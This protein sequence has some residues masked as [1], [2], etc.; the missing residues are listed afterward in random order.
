MAFVTDNGT[1]L[2]TCGDSAVV[3]ARQRHA[4]RKRVEAAGARVR[5][6]HRQ[7]EAALIA[8]QRRRAAKLAYR[9]RTSFDH[10]LTELDRAH[11]EMGRRKSLV[12]LKTIASSVSLSQET[13]EPYKVKLVP[14]A[15]KPWQ[16]RIIC[17]FG[18]VEKAR[19]RMLANTLRPVNKAFCAS[20]QFG[21]VNG[22]R[23]AAIKR[24]ESVMNDP[25]KKWVATAD[26]ANCYSSIDRDMLANLIRRIVPGKVL[27]SAGC[28][29]REDRTLIRTW[30][31]ACHGDLTMPITDMG[32]YAYSRR[33]I[34][35]G[36]AASSFIAD[37][38]IGYAL[39]TI[40]LPSGV[41]I[42]FYADDVCILGD[43]KDE[44]AAA[45]EA[46]GAHFR[47]LPV[48]PLALKAKRPRK[49]ADG[50]DFIGMT[51]R[52]RKGYERVVTKVGARKAAQRKLLK[53]ALSASETGCIRGLKTAVYGW[54]NAN[55]A[56]ASSLL[57]MHH[58][59]RQLGQIIG[60][61]AFGNLLKERAC[62][63][64]H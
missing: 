35:P 60:R 13:S 26:V 46:L 10:K 4:D 19:Q 40:V 50:F 42:V 22:G 51:F 52:R 54:L 56:W 23:Q 36:G 9:L 49:I 44:V 28:A 55:R 18:P 3:D 39:A 5:K 48:G 12:E 14:K 31:Y 1:G 2:L 34:T 53:L 6:L 15:S 7:I 29:E 58:Q 16:R 38:V 43:S 27:R 63:A 33:G 24:I 62:N 32:L 30:G 57:W 25:R 20:D 11:R 47:E 64:L 59:L 41:I 8:G 21:T 61:V 45:T 37:L 17:A